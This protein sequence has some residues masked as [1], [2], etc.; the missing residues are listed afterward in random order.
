[1]G[2]KIKATRE[3]ELNDSIIII[4]DHIKILFVTKESAK[5]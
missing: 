5:T 1:M 4:L 2:V 3:L